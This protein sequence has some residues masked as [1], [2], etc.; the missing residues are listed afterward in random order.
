MDMV[1]IDAQLWWDT[2]LQASDKGYNLRAKL[3]EEGN[4]CRKTFPIFLPAGNTVSPQSQVFKAAFL[5]LLQ[6]RTHHVLWQEG[7]RGTLAFPLPQASQVS[8]ASKPGLRNHKFPNHKC[9]WSPGCKSPL[10]S[11]GGTLPH[12]KNFN[13]SFKPQ[14]KKVTPKS[15]YSALVTVPLTP[16]DGQAEME[17]S[18]ALHFH[19]DTRQVTSMAQE[20]FLRQGFKEKILAPLACVTRKVTMCCNMVLQS[21][22]LHMPEMI[23]QFKNIQEN[24]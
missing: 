3:N 8:S 21:G 12:P 14:L 1:L 16:R 2:P 4:K 23:L 10:G 20:V 19:G 11:T 24:H 17:H 7:Q 13:C 15:T 6:G 5:A 9:S 22:D 18:Q